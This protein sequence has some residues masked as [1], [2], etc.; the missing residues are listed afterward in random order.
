MPSKDASAGQRPRVCIVRQTHYYEMPVRR[1][2]EALV[3]AGY[4]VELIHMRGADGKGRE[5]INGV[6]ISTL[7]GKLGKSRA[8]RRI[9]EEVEIGGVGNQMRGNPAGGM[10]FVQRA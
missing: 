9:T 10:P 5:V 4:D 2:A 1:E 3:G 7:P 8:R 6:S